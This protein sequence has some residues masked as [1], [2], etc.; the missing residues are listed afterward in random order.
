METYRELEDFGAFTQWEKTYDD[1]GTAK[2]AVEK[3]SSVEDAFQ[4]Q[5][6]GWR[7]QV[8]HDNDNF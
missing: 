2:I 5:E 4:A 1:G 7:G 6:E 8:Y 3:G